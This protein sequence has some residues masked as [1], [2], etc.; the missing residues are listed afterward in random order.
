M[1]NE[2]KVKKVCDG[3]ISKIENYELAMNDKI[4]YWHCHHRRG[5]IFSRKELI[6]IGQYYNRPPEELIFLTKAEHTR[7]HKI[8]NKNMLGK[9]TKGLY[10][11][12]NG[13]FGK[14]HTEEAR[15]K[16]SLKHKGKKLSESQKIALSKARNGR[17]LSEEQKRKISETRKLRCVAKGKNNPMYGRKRGHMFNNGKI[18]VF[19]LECPEGFVKGKLKTSLK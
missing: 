9:H 16:M 3:D 6:E 5:T 19:A 1:I 15:R 12:K 17:K 18:N 10:G 14:H 13:M 8:G 4:Q 2:Y 11:D 7:I